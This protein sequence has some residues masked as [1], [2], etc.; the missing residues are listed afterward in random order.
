VLPAE[1]DIPHAG[2]NVGPFDHLAN[3]FMLG[4]GDDASGML[5]DSAKQGAM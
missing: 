3:A 1:L 2:R 4:S 5:A